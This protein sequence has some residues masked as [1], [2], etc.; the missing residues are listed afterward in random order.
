MRRLTASAEART[1]RTG[2]F[3]DMNCRAANCEAP[4]TTSMENAMTWLSGKPASVA[5]T[6]K[7]IA[8]GITT[9]TKGKASS[10]PRQ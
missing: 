3:S 1:T 10:K 9:I 7:S 2:A 6:P 8:N 4:A 5:T